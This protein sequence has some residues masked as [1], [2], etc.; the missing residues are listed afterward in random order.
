MLTFKA[1]GQLE[2]S[3]LQP[4]AEA[5]RFICCTGLA[6][7]AWLNLVLYRAN[8]ALRKQ[9]ALK[10]D[11]SQ[12]HCISLATALT[13]HIPLVLLCLRSEH[14]WERFWFSIPSP[15]PTVR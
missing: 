3:Q 7:F 12:W 11:Y 10:T 1:S 4:V 14:I 2:L 5:D 13:S 6:V 8:D 15:V 9:V